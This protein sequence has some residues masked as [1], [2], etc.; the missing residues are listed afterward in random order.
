MISNILYLDYTNRI[1]L[2]GGQR[3][4]ALL[5]R[6]LDRSRFLPLI[7]CPSGERFRQMLDSS[8]PVFDLELRRGFS[9]L[10][11]HQTG[12]MR[13][14]GLLAGSLPAVRQLRD[15]LDRR[16]VNIVHA[17]NLKM[18]WLAAAAAA[19][20]HIPILWHVRDIYP[21]TA[22]NQTILRVAAR[23]ATRVITVS[24]A[25]AQQFPNQ[26]NITVIHNAVEMPALDGLASP[27]ADFRARFGIPPDAK[28]A[29]YVG[30]LDD[31]KGVDTLIESFA[32]SRMPRAGWRLAI[33]GEGAQRNALETLASQ[34][35]V[36]RTLHFIPFQHD[37]AS[38]YSAMDLT[39][40]PSTEP[41]PFPR[42]VIEAMSFGKAVIGAA[43]GGIPEAIEDRVT[44]Y[45]FEPG[46]MGQ[47]V[48]MLNR[49][50][51][52]PELASQMGAAGRKRCQDLFSAQLQALRIRQLYEE[53]LGQP[54]QRLRAA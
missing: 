10:S 6:H 49:I 3:S 38:A 48:A 7:A 43:T 23:L 46:H 14:P 37:I 51:H 33:V 45:C 19:G 31:W 32:A 11:R 41:D 44:G 50:E 8:V 15:L 24:R 12:L 1:G 17:N 13:L 53:I 20:R 26:P 40:Q 25:V 21:P 42:S 47:L 18:L 9:T 22:I 28:L 35:G 54:N 36:A 30:R 2:G 29:G 5:L 4:L 16:R 39:V 52:Q 34:R 27:A